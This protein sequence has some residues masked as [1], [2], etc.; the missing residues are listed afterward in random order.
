PMQGSTTHTP[1]WL[2]LVWQICPVGQPS[3]K[4]SRQRPCLHVVPV[5]Q[6]NPSQG[7]MQ[8]PVFGSQNSSSLQV[9]LK[10]GLG[11]QNRPSGRVWQKKL[12]G[13]GNSPAA[14]GPTHCAL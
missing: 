9:L 4:Q 13:Q 6:V 12:N 7:L 1:M 8:L 14:Q 11:T 2:A 10:Q 5:G 3:A